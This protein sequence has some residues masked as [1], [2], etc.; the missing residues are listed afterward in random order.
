MSIASSDFR[1]YRFLDDPTS[2]CDA[3]D[4]GKSIHP[5]RSAHLSSVKFAKT[6]DVSVNSFD[7]LIGIL[8]S[9]RA[10]A[11]EGRRDAELVCR[12]NFS[13]LPLVVR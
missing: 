8:C 4:P 11:N 7:L 10:A 3:R 13:L 6:L 9:T 2:L 5:L 12:H 1:K